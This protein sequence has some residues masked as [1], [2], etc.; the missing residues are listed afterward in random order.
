MLSQA[1]T[2]TSEQI[3][4][5][6]RCERKLPVPDMPT[7]KAAASAERAKRLRGGVCGMLHTY[8]HASASRR[9]TQLGYHRQHLHWPSMLLVV[10]LG[11]H[12]FLP[13]VTTCARLPELS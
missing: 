3:A 5:H 2:F 13:L 10:V 4:A 9:V 7:N 1:G 12:A 11:T 8:M 6:H